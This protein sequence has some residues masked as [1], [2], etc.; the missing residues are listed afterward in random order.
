MRLLPLPLLV[1]VACAHPPSAHHHATPH[2][3]PHRFEDPDAWAP[4]FEDPA[5]D[6]WQKPDEVIAALKLQPT[7]RIADIGAATGYFPV[8]IARALPN[9]KV[10][11]VDIEPKM[12]KYLADRATHEGLPN[13]K[14]VLGTPDDT[15]LPEKVELV[16]MVDTFH[17]VEHRV[18][19]FERLK[20]HV[21][22]DGRLA[23]ID[24][25]PDAPI[26]PPPAH[27]I[28]VAQIVTELKQA[29][30]D[31]TGEHDFLPYQHFVTFAPVR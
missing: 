22:A 31:K 24:F 16:L 27:R 17:H 7:D 3:M 25:R 12:T 4:R 26:G 6:A 2:A 21:T 8:R 28:P 23:I 15:Q 30:W 9:A 5:R 10:Y 20:Q 29:G 11:G 14:A 18:R 1:L 13:L 19:Y